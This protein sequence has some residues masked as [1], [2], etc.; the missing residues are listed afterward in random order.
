MTSTDLLRL[1]QQRASSAPMM[2][3][4]SCRLSGKSLA[5]QR[6]GLNFCREWVA[7]SMQALTM[8]MASRLLPLH[9]QQLRA[10]LG[11]PPAQ[12]RQLLKAV[13]LPALQGQ[14]CV[15]GSAVAACQVAR[16]AA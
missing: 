3:G 7:S 6:L 8:V 1:L 13:S 15:T 9:I 12:A 5:G 11:E 2:Q 4:M 14:E 10:V 16:A